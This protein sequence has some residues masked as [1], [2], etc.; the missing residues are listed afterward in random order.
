MSKHSP[1]YNQ[2]TEEYYNIAQEQIKDEEI[3]P[4]VVPSYKRGDNALTI[5]L[6]KDCPELNVILFVYEDDV[7]NYQKTLD[8]FKNFSVVKCVLCEEDKIFEDNRVGLEKRGIEYKRAAINNKMVQMGYDRYFVMDDDICALYYTRHGKK[9]DG[10]YKAEK[11]MVNPTQFFKMWQYIINEKATDVAACGIISENGSWC[12]DLVTM[13]DITYIAGQVQIIYINGKI[14]KDNNINYRGSAGWEDYDFTL[15]LIKNGLNSCQIRYMTYSTP[16]MTPGKSVAT[17]NEYGVVT[18]RDFGWTK[19]SMNLYKHWG[20]LTRFKLKKEQLN[21]KIRWVTIRNLI[22]KTGK[23]EITYNEEYM[24]FIN[25]NDPEGLYNYI[26]K[27]EEE[28]EA[29]KTIKKKEN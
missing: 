22:K 27:Q 1:R 2:W 19:R 13:E 10:N 23:I 24:K 5:K 25:N 28:K 18:E 12:Q 26:I 17:T 7:Q 21:C 16:T 15:E 29:K 8:E 9:N 20:E 3:Y 11:V 14:I 4:I 6:L